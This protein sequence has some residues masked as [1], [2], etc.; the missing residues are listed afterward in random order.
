M[1]RR[2][3]AKTVEEGR[4]LIGDMRGRKACYDMCYSELHFFAS[5]LQSF[6]IAE[7]LYNVFLFGVALGAR[8]QK[9]KDKES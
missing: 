8:A 5:M 2:N 9:K 3:I 4:L 7:T 1:K 6:S